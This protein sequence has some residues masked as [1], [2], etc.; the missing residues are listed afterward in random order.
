MRRFI[1]LLG[2]IFLA[3]APWAAAQSASNA[4]VWTRW[5][6]SMTSSKSYAN[7]YA[8]VTVSVRY[9]G[10]G[11]QSFSSYG[12]WDGG[13]TWRI[14]SAFPAT[15]TWNWS[16]SSSDT[17]NT[18]LHNRSGSVSVAGFGGTNP[19]YQR[20]FLK[21]SSSKR[22]LVHNDGTPFLWM[23]DSAWVGPLKGS[24]ADWQT[25][26]DD[27]IAK[28]FTLTQITCGA[29]GWASNTDINGNAP[30]IGSGI[31]R[32]NPPFWQELDRKLQYANDRGLVLLV[33]GLMEPTFRYPSSTDAV[34]FARNL[35]ARLAGNFVILSPSFDS[36]YSALGNDVGNAA[37]GASSRHLVTQHVGTSLTAA[38]SYYDQGY[39]DLSGCQSGHNRGDR[40]TCAFNA[41]EWNLDLYRR[42]PFKP[43][44]N[45]E[46]YY[47]SNG[48][49]SG[50]TAT[51][52]GTA[53][54][55]RQ[56][57]Y[58]S[59]MS[60]SLGYTY[61]AFGLWD[62]EK[63]S[64]KGN[65]WSKAMQF[66][67]AAQM[68]HMR[69]LFASME[70]W[71]L[72]PNHGLIK[73]QPAEYRRRMVLAKTSIGDLAVAYMPDNPSMVVDM[74]AFPTAM[75]GQWLNP[76]SGAYTAGP[77]SVPNTGR[78]T[79]N[80]PSSGDWVLVL[81][82]AGGGSQAPYGGTPRAIPGTIQIEDFDT[83]GEGVAYRDL[84]TA[85]NGGA[86]RTEGVD[87][88]VTAD[89]GG[90][91]DVGW[92]RAGEWL[93][94]TVNVG[95]SGTYTLAARV[96]SNGPGGT[97][98]VEFNGV[99]K[100]GVIVAPN[101]GS[102]QNWT[103]LT[104]TVSLSAGAQVMRIAMDANGA[105]G[106]IANINYVRLTA[107]QAPPPPPTAVNL[108]PNGG[109]EG[110][111]WT[112]GSFVGSNVTSWA[113]DQSRSPTHSLKT[114]SGSAYFN[115][116]KSAKFP[117][118]PG[119]SYALSAWIRTQ[120]LAADA[121]WSQGVMLNLLWL[122]GGGT[123]FAGYYA[124]DGPGIR[125]TVGWTKKETTVKAPSGAATAIVEFRVRANSGA[126]WIDDASL[127]P[128]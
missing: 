19:L 84:D 43:V 82:L 105:T 77:G 72:E 10:P 41:I 107:M 29:P 121:G 36:E 63:D 40:E 86:Y 9:T 123:V 14:R 62:W 26:V 30:F 38:R 2:L 5:E 22:H 120:S 16:T 122:D 67:S 4:T 97:F 44:V 75:A 98:H 50:L 87:I 56:L 115:Y 95:S 39:L 60:G 27:R 128:Q 112:A 93:E 68:T 23:G 91:Y 20:G 21:V 34:R 104:K 116:F 49:A 24:M 85:N 69:N 33:V 47:D 76:V 102:W 64:N 90:G 58:L 126:A 80:A 53:K 37:S 114:S 8:D 54:D 83:G 12:F 59:W 78:Y 15:G 51:Y 96:A 71:R 92:T 125:G 94:Y 3:V 13:S 108:V 89:A 65:H 42:N 103:T 18:G 113:T 46:A 79:F 57:G 25:Y 11:G 73:N 48:T 17:S 99:D 88:Q 61:G 32:W 81:R 110:G 7:P 1:I 55:A 28:R 66:P 35:V 109:M 31:S 124:V 111:K 70:W 119:Q 101:T 52:Q 118:T 127:I 45:L 74:A 117:V 100:T 106:S 6:A